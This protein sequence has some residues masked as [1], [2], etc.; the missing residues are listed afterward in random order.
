MLDDYE[1]CFKVKNNK[2][3]DDKEIYNS[4][5]KTFGMIY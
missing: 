5:K 3:I 2:I 4:D 1:T